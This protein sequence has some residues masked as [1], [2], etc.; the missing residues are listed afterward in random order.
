MLQA[1]PIRHVV[2]AL[3][4]KVLCCS[5]RLDDLIESFSI[6]ADLTVMNGQVVHDS[7][8]FGGRT[9]PLQ[10]IEPSWSPVRSYGG[11]YRR[12]EREG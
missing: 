8:E 9:R 11:Y 12:M 7:G 4:G 10:A 3:D 5:D 2:E 1:V 6:E